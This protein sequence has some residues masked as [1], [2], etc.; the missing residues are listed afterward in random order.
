MR[1]QSYGEKPK[2]NA[3]VGTAG[4]EE[5]GRRW[6]NTKKKRH[7]ERG[8]QLSDEVPVMSTQVLMRATAL[9]DALLGDKPA[10]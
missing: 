1:K 2:L 3:T 6:N 9:V 10:T 5:A 7:R 8:K 4:K